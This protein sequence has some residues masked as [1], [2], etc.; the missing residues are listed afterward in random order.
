MAPSLKQS[1]LL[2]SCYLYYKEQRNIKDIAEQ[3]GISRF[4]V[5]RFLTE[6]IETGVVQVQFLDPSMQTERMALELGSAY[7]LRRV[8]I[9]PTP[10]NADIESKRQAVGRLG[11]ELLSDLSSDAVIG[12]TWG[13]TVAHMVESFAPNG[14]KVSQVVELAG[15]FGQI[16]SSVAARVVA[17]RLAEKLNA[18]CIQVVAPIIADTPQSAAMLLAESSIVRALDLAEKADIAVVGVGPASLDSLLYRSSY[19]TEKDFERLATVNAVGSVIGR[20]YDITGAPVVADPW[21]RVVGL[22]L[23][24]FCRIP[25][26]IAVAAGPFKIESIVGLARGHLITTLVTDSETASALMAYHLAHEGA[27]GAAAAPAAKKRKTPRGTQ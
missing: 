1:L 8:L 19:L 18:E 20:F 7:G 3:L 6:A 24:R 13:R 21:D 17:L 12:I 26:R 4:R 15:G 5:S 23:E 11:A 22:T 2:R 25:E 16:S 9:A 10:E 14:A 27:G